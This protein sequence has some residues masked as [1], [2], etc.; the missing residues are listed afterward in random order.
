MLSWDSSNT[1]ADPNYPN[2]P[3]WERKEMLYHKIIQYFD[4]GKVICVKFVVFI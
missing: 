1:V 4:R 2:T 3:E